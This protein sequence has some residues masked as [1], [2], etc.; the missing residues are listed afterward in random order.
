MVS[1]GSCG[2]AWWVKVWTEWWK[3]GITVK[4]GLTQAQLHVICSNHNESTETAQVFCVQVKNS[5]QISD[6]PSVERLNYCTFSCNI[7]YSWK[8]E[9]SLWREWSLLIFC[10]LCCACTRKHTLASYTSSEETLGLARDLEGED[11]TKTSSSMSSWMGFM[12]EED[13]GPGDFSEKH[14]RN[15]VKIKQLIPSSLSW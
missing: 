14:Q 5:T 4:T 8:S 3:Y 2:G 11:S 1:S 12:F 9:G 7:T 15:Q 13:L 10:P 6:I